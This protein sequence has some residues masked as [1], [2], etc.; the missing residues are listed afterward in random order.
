MSRHPTARRRPSAAQRC[1]AQELRPLQMCRA[2]FAKHFGGIGSPNAGFCTHFVTLFVDAK[3]WPPGEGSWAGFCP[4]GRLLGIPQSRE[5]RYLPTTAG[6]L[7]GPARGR[8]ISSTVISQLC[9]VPNKRPPG[10]NP[11]LGA[12]SGRPAIG[13]RARSR[14]L[15]QRGPSRFRTTSCRF[16][17][18]P[19]SETPHS[20]FSQVGSVLEPP[21]PPVASGATGPPWQSWAPRPPL[22]PPAGGYPQKSRRNCKSH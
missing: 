22:S 16:R 6:A 8:R 20:I 17:I 7:R 9:G 11:A 3:R 13:M 14:A 5:S 2:R 12:Q 15:I 1:C 19:K 10:Q 18:V 4:G 21:V